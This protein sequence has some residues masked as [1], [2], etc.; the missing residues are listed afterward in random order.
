MGMARHIVISCLTNFTDFR[1][2][3]RLKARGKKGKGEKG[4][5][6]RKRESN[7]N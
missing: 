1:K 2:L 4:K 3:R 6:K 7:R 5:G